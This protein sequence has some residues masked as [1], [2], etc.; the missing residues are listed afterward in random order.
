MPESPTEPKSIRIFVSSTF[1]DMGQERDVLVQRT[2]GRLRR[3]TEAAGTTLQEIDFRWGVTTEEKDSGEVLDICLGEIDACRPFFIAVLGER[4]GWIDPTTRAKLSRGYPHLVRFYD[5]SLTELEI[6]HAILNSPFEPDP[7]TNFFYIRSTC[8]DGSQPVAPEVH[9]LIQEIRERDLSVRVFA[10]PLELDALV[11]ADLLKAIRAHLPKLPI[12]SFANRAQTAY[13]T[14]LGAPGFQRWRELHR[15]QRALWFWRRIVIQAP[16]GAGKS[17]LL[18]ALHRSASGGSR[19]AS[20]TASGGRW[21]TMIEAIVS[22]TSESPLGDDYTQLESFVENAVGLTLI[23]AIDE[24]EG[25]LVGSVLEWIPR[26]RPRGAIVVSTSTP[27][28]SDDLRKLGFRLFSIRPL[29]ERELEAIIR[30]SL[31]RFGKHL[32]PNAMR[33]IVKRIP[34]RTPAYTRTF[35]ELLRQFG[36]FEGLDNEVDRLLS[37][38]TTRRLFK[39]ALARLEQ[40]QGMN[41][42]YVRRALAL[43]LAARSG[44]T[45][46][47]VLILSGSPSRPAPIRDWAPI[48]YTLAPFFFDRGGVLSIGT[49]SLI[50]AIIERY[51]IGDDTLE[52]ARRELARHFLEKAEDPRSIDELVFLLPKIRGWSEGCALLTDPPWLAAAYERD[53]VELGAF[54]ALIVSGEPG[55]SDQLF[56]RIALNAL[57]DASGVSRVG[58]AELL[59]RFGRPDQAAEVCEFALSSSSAMKTDRIRHALQLLLVESRIRSGQARVALSAL[60]GLHDGTRSGIDT[61]EMKERA[62]LLALE[63]GESDLADY[64]IRE[65]EEA[66]P[67][68]TPSR[69]RVRLQLH[70]CTVLLA[71]G[72]YRN[73]LKNFS[74]LEG[75]VRRLQDAE[76][77]TMTLSGRAIALRQLGRPRRALKLHLEEERLWR[78]LGDAAGLTRCLVNQ[79][80]VRIDLDDFDAADDLLE[81]ADEAASVTGNDRLSLDV[82][83]RQ[84][85]FLEKIGMA[86]GLR[87]VSIRGA[88][89]SIQARVNEPSLRNATTQPLLYALSHGVTGRFSTGAQTGPAILGADPK[90][91]SKR[92]D[93]SDQNAFL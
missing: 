79:A 86:D 87:A 44:L 6:R 89:Q 81:K 41:S 3:I 91:I 65:A 14:Y 93:I 8:L 85:A 72:R 26:V 61:A 76:G 83:R 40:L 29:N 35:V 18:L 25:A 30:E 10:E 82:K 15:L 42:G 75:R 54:V 19:F 38:S 45:E 4:Y 11:E 67:A 33:K 47:E 5:R 56:D 80:L 52:A 49:S 34:E 92:P 46:N 7:T 20:L 77:L 1:I 13:Q 48:H 68:K 55:I 74:E 12:P 73:A 31:I 50:A 22:D 59:M 24:N 78:V 63:L 27:G 39:L 60:V 32:S 2:F 88:I 62:A 23:D 53:P 57:D 58:A 70:S 71:K 90:M 69:L 66:L 9:R 17:T 84:L 51:A 37:A 21:S 64:L 16:D 28:I 43:I 36:L